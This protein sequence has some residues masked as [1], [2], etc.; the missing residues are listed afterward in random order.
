MFIEQP[1]LHWVCQKSRNHSTKKACNL[2]TKNIARIAK[3][4]P[5]NITLVVKCVKLL[6]PKVLRKFYFLSTF[7][8]SNLT[9]LKTDVMFSGQRFAI[10]AMFFFILTN[11]HIHFLKSWR[12]I[13]LVRPHQVFS[14]LCEGPASTVQCGNLC[15]C[16]YF[17][18]TSPENMATNAIF[19]NNLPN[20]LCTSASIWSIRTTHYVGLEKFLEIYQY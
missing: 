18:T 8:K 17:R 11:F 1:W 7:G 14:S 15:L 6:F 16:Q 4:C 5:E 12:F 13:K 9:H 3:R 19:K 2:S 20:L 10:L